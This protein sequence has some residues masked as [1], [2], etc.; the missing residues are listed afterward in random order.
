MNESIDPTINESI[1]QSMNQSINQS[2]NQSMNQSIKVNLSMQAK[3]L[4]HT[5][6]VDRP[7]KLPRILIITT[8]WRA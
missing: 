1:N 2:M 6:L 4:L 7:P 8:T 3:Q 5:T